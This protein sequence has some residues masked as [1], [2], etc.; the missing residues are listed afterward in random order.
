[1]VC[2][3]EGEGTGIKYMG[4]WDSDELTASPWNQPTLRLLCKRNDVQKLIYKSANKGGENNGFLA[5]GEKSP[6]LQ[7][8]SGGWQK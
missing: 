6:R 3:H 4:N 2:V 7:L 8:W 5:A 1:M